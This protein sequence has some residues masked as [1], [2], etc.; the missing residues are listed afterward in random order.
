[1]LARHLAIVSFCACSLGLSAVR[2]DYAPRPIAAEGEPSLSLELR[3][4]LEEEADRAFAWRVTWTAINA[5]VGGASFAGVFVL[6]KSQEPSLIVGGVASCLTALITWL[7]PLE[8]ESAAR[9][10]GQRGAKLRELYVAAAEDE[11][12]R[13]QWPWHLLNVALSAIPGVIIWAGYEQLENGLITFSTGV[14]LGELALFTQPNRLSD[15]T[16]AALAGLRVAPAGR[17]FVVGYALTF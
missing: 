10:A 7:L 1:M 17:G 12:D 9:E 4:A 13:V 6:P 8:V 11:S 14:V 2:A 5:A 15:R 16:L 3:T